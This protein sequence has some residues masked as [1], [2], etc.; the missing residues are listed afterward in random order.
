MRLHIERRA[1]ATVAEMGGNGMLFS[2][3]AA[4][5]NEPTYI[6]P[7]KQGF[8][9]QVAPE[10]FD[11]VLSQRQDVR[12]LFNH[13]PNLLLG[14]TTAGTLRLKS[15]T[16]GGGLHQETDL[17]DTQ[18]GRDVRTLTERR[19]LTGQSIGFVVAPGGDQWDS[20]GGGHGQVRTI[21]KIGTLLDVSAVT[22]PAYPTTTAGVRSMWAVL[23]SEIYGRLAVT[24]QR[25]A[26][27]SGGAAESI[28]KARAADAAVDAACDALA[29][30]NKAQ[31]V[32]LLNAA[33][34]AIDGAGS[35]VSG[36]DGDTAVA[37]GMQDVGKLFLVAD[38]SIAAAVG[39][40]SSSENPDP[41]ALATACSAL[42]DLLAALGTDDPDKDKGADPVA[43]VSDGTA[44]PA[45]KNVSTPDSSADGA[46]SKAGG[47]GGAGGV[48]PSTAGGNNGP[49]MRSATPPASPGTNEAIAIRMRVARAATTL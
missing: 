37:L 14:R 15:D 4:R 29:D 47:N 40:I 12:S 46:N 3:Y 2:G 9:E 18:L 28:K 21:T 24:E 1:V 16:S 39:T 11:D 13:D 48:A 20:R 36:L 31:A 33:A 38:H 35:G 34:I 23:R 17:P 32:D 41:A 30:G 44:P 49:G 7:P 42:R 43:P 8:H 27:I 22:Y 19:D 5:F 26:A 25:A 6:G 45:T 10:A